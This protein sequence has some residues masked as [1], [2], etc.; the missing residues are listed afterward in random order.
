VARGAAG[1]AATLVALTGFYT[2]VY[3]HWRV[4]EH[5]GSPWHG[6][7]FPVDANR[8][9]FEAGV[10]SGP[11]AGA[12][13][14]LAGRRLGWPW[15]GVAAGLLLLSEP[16]ALHLVRHRHLPGIVLGVSDRRVEHAAVVAGA[17]VVGL[18]AVATQ[19]ARVHRLRS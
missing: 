2:G 16:S 17:V 5:F 8:V 12:V 1:L 9:W 13:A 19:V 4:H 3:A 10:L 18:S 11:V 7:W 14:A 6:W 15:L